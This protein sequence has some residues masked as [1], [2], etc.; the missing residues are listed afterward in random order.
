M[1]LKFRIVSALTLSALF[2]SACGSVA[3]PRYE[4][5]AIIAEAN[6]EATAIVAEARESEIGRAH[7]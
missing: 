3:T 6:R 4:A 1:G 2:M 7:V 5:D